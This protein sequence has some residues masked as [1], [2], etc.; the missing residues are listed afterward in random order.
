MLISLRAAVAARPGCRALAAGIRPGFGTHIFAVRDV[1]KDA[2]AVECYTRNLK[3]ICETLALAP[4]DIR[5]LGT[6]GTHFGVRDTHFFLNFPPLSAVVMHDRALI[7]SEVEDEPAAVLLGLRVNEVKGRPSIFAGSMDQSMDPSM[8]QL[9][10]WEHSVLDAALRET[11]Q[12]KQD[13]FARLSMLIRQD[14]RHKV[15]GQA[16]LP[17]FNREMRLYRLLNL[18]H[19]LATLAVEVN[20]LHACSERCL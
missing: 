12:H 20:R 6:R 9:S 17:S 7:V 13:R 2:E 11:L 8:D 4:R 15:V 18:S 14:L 3:E 16:W 1:R 5:L 10:P 19:S